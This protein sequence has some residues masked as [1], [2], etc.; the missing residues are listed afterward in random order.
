MISVAGE[1]LSV[2]TKP[3]AADGERIPKNGSHDLGAA[4]RLSTRAFS[5]KQG[6]AG[7]P[8]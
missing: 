5:P 8:V 3:P 2:E 7:G 1:V 6:G 4:A